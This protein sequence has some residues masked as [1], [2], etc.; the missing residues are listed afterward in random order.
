MIRAK[1]RIINSR[2]SGKEFVL[3]GHP[4][5]IGRSQENDFVIP[6][7]SVSRQHVRVE[8]N[9][10]RCAVTDLGSHNGIVLGGKTLRKAVLNKG[11]R[12]ELGDVAI[13]FTTEEVKEQP[14]AQAPAA[15]PA[16]AAGL[17][18]AVPEGYEL[19]KPA[20]GVPGER[21]V[22]VDDLL[23]LGSVAEAQSGAEEKAAV[24]GAR[25]A[26][27]YLLVMAVIIALGAV[28]WHFAGDRSVH[29]NIKPVIV[30]AGETKV[31][32]LGINIRTEGGRVITYIDHR[33]SYYETPVDPGDED[34]AELT[35]EATSSG[36]TGFMAT[37]T[38]HDIDRETDVVLAGPRGRRCIVRILVRGAVSGPPVNERLSNEERIAIARQL[39]TGAYSALQAD[40][41]YK[42]MKKFE[43]AEVVL[44]R[45]K[46]SAGL[47]LRRKAER[48]NDRAREKI[49]EKFDEIKFQALAMLRERDD[50][51]V[52]K[53]VEE[54]RNLIPD[55]EDH[56]HKKLQIIW[57]RTL[58][59]I[60]RKGK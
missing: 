21:P 57:E 52:A 14:A 58:D 59:R 53:A 24:S 47:A 30:K 23:G 56:R 36:N 51:G 48:E 20:A 45:V 28:A 9:G 38:G 1:L 33:E 43:R 34:V 7:Q 41:V 19:A 50:R 25:S 55:E 46:T 8:L 6:D 31:I 44:Q 18:P 60:R 16:A 5:T 12:F 42:A 26:A 13:E 39:M 22:F 3:P 11:D 29:E 10:G 4:V 37:I 2:L 49:K 17:A 15:G 54:L 27:K 32:D 35:V 40:Y